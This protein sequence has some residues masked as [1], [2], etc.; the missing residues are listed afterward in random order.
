MT[1]NSPSIDAIFHEALRRSDPAVRE[2]YLA[3][4]CRGDLKLRAQVDR[5]LSSVSQMGDFLNQP[6]LALVT[7]IN[8]ESLAGQLI[9]PFKLLEK[10]GEGGMGVVY[11]AE[12]DE[13]VRRRVAVKVIRAGMDSAQVV[14]RFDQERQ[15]LALMDH[16]NIARVLDAG[17]TPDGRPYF[18]ME[19]VEGA[20]IT[21]HCDQN[22]LSIDERIA[23]FVPVCQ[24]VQHAHQKGIIHRDLK[25]S[26]VIVTVYD[27]KPIPKVIDFG[28]AKAI[29]TH[30]LERTAFTESGQIVGTMEYMAPEQAEMSPNAAGDVDTRADIYSLGVL[31]YELLTGSPPFSPRQLR[32]AGL[33]E[34]L[35]IIKE[36][37]PSKPSTKITGAEDLPN[38]AA[39]RRLDPQKLVRRVSGELDWITMKCL[40][41]DRSRRYETANGLASDLQR[42]LADEPVQ[43]CPPTAR[44]RLLKFVRRHRVAVLAASLISVSLVGGFIGTMVGLWNARQQHA[45]VLAAQARESQAKQREKERADAEGQ[46]RQRATAAEAE[47]NAIVEFLRGDLLGQAG[48]KAQVDR[49]FKPNPNLTVREALDR[50]A[51]TAGKK[52]KDRPV[53]EAAIR[54]T[55][56]DSY[57]QLGIYEKAIEQLRIAAELQTKFLGEQNKLTVETQYS[58]AFSLRGAQQL[59]EAI[60]LLEQ[61][62]AARRHELG[63][64]DPT[65]LITLETLAVVYRDAGRIAE[66]AKILEQVRVGKLQTLGAEHPST[67]VTLHNLATMYLDANQPQKAIESLEQVYQT[68]VKV[69]GA[70]NPDTLPA[71]QNLAVAYWKAQQ[72]DQSIPRFEECLAIHR[73]VFGDEHPQT[74]AAMA[75]LGVNYRDAGQFDQAI[76][77][78][79]QVRRAGA[80]QPSLAWVGRELLIAYDKAGK[81]E[82]A[83]TLN[84]ELLNE[85]IKS[86]PAD[87]PQRASAL[88]DA[89]VNLI[90]L[91]AWSDAEILLRECLAIREKREPNE[92]RTFSTQAYLGESLLGQE[93]FSE[94]EPLLLQGHAG[95]SQRETSIPPTLKNRLPE[96]AARLVQLYEAWGKPDDADKWRTK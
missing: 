83:I 66:A 8:N 3:E 1:M 70:E 71:L 29:S 14:A 40:E 12:Q 51:A 60:T 61:V 56:G 43:A 47:S 81:R 26:N 52:F 85:S 49:H 77:R 54:K 27:A 19:L 75:N 42:F 16:P 7:E 84:K 90:R 33:G 48:S 86:I 31:L 39:N 25:P 30:H 4:A 95:L 64:N 80:G 53:L 2:A 46:E 65:T 55:L 38:V 67:L 96:I 58:L 69:L 92:W 10:L 50:A 82:Q 72:L 17:A 88:A 45:A 59:D 63:E 78:L 87:S 57:L 24:A 22:H 9:G 28:V 74:L 89:G 79:E 41:K 91:R 94:A 68:K 11:R 34:M 32:E 73:K 6:V 23:L 62:L 76:E 13:P 5:L 15:A 21:R 20:S 36:V 18:A 93:K 44:Y 37:E 35:R